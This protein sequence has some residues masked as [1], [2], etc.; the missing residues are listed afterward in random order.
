LSAGG[1]TSVESSPAAMNDERSQPDVVLVE[2]RLDPGELR[3]LVAAHFEDMVKYVVD[4]Q[5]GVAAVG[6]ELHADEE[7]VLL[8]QG[9]RQDEKSRDRFH[10]IFPN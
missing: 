4:V 9:S 5:R 7:A 2:D 3:R 1:G 6:G 8:E 10:W